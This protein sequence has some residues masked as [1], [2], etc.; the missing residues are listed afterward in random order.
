VVSSSLS[1]AKEHLATI[2]LVAVI[3]LWLLITNLPEAPSDDRPTVPLWGLL[4]GLVLAV[5]VCNTWT[6]WYLPTLRAV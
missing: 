4:L 2:G 6:G 3:G 5:L 1:E